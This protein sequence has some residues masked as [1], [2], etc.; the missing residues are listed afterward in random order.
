V[1][2]LILVIGAFSVVAGF[3]A[4][5]FE[6]PLLVHIGFGVGS[7]VLGV[8]FGIIA[9]LVKHGSV[10][11]ILLAIMLF[12]ADSLYSSVRVMQLWNQSPIAV[13]GVRIWFL[14]PMIRAL[15]AMRD[16]RRIPRQGTAARAWPP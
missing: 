16:L 11:A 6:V 1:S 13:L 5:L 9:F 12:V 8:L 3:A 15:F 2:I 10:I 4:A 7:I 14:L